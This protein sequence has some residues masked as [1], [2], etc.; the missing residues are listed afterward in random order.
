MNSVQMADHL[1]SRAAAKEAGQPRLR[2]PF[3]PLLLMGVAVLGWMAFQTVTLMQDRRGLD[4]MLTAQQPQ[5]VQSARLRAA[6]SSL[7]GDTQKLADAGDPGAHLIV[8]QLKQ[9][10]ITIHPSDASTAQP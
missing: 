8:N 1:T 2:S 6:L 7:A 10:G 3:L 9:R 4:R 5:V